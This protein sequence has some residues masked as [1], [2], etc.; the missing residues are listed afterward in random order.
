M[1]L[2][3]IEYFL[4]TIFYIL[5]NIDIIFKFNYN[6]NLNKNQK[7]YDILLCI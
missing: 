7:M 1:I 5:E 4:V 6:V 2:N 3:I